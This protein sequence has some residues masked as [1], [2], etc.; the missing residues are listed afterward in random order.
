[1]STA[2]DSTIQTICWEVPRTIILFIKQNQSS[3]QKQKK[4]IKW[5]LL[6]TE[7]SQPFKKWYQR[8]IIIMSN[9]LTWYALLWPRLGTWHTLYNLGDFRASDESRLIYGSSLKEGEVMS[10][11][12][13]CWK[14]AFKKTCQG[15]VILIGGCTSSSLKIIHSLLSYHPIWV[16]AITENF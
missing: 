15:S 13:A 10:S 11:Q 6:M 8:N 1:M 5:R 7:T 2:Q 9:Q 12:G 16:L 14:S 3:K 4:W